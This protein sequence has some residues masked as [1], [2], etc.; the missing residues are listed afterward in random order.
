MTKRA[1][2]V[3]HAI[4]VVGFIAL[5][6]GEVASAQAAPLSID[7]ALA[8][9]SFQPYAPIPV[10]PDGRW[11]AYTLKY[12]DRATDEPGG[13][14]TRTGISSVA[15]GTRVRIT[16]VATGRT[17]PVGPDSATSWGPSWSPDG[18]YLAY[19][20][21]TDGIS[22]LWVRETATGRTRR[23]SNA[24]V[25]AHQ[26]IQYPRWTPDSRR[27]VMPILPYGS[28]RPEA[29]IDS[30]TT[31]AAR[32]RTDSATVRVL[33]ADPAM[34]YGGQAKGARDTDPHDALR[35]DLGLVDVVSGAV[36]TLAT[37]YWPLEYS[38][39]AD[40]RYVTFSSEKP[41]VFRTRWMVPYDLM[42][43][44]IRDGV[45]GPSRRIAKDVAITN[46]SRGVFWSPRGQ[47]LAFSATDSTG[48]EQYFAADSS[49]WAPRLVA[50]SQAT[51]LAADSIAA[52][53]SFWSRSWSRSFWWD[54]TGRAIHIVGAHAVATVSMPDGRVRSV[55]R[56]PVDYEP[57]AVVETIRR[58]AAWTSGGRELT[59][60]FRN[61]VTK[62]MGFGRI[63]LATGAWRVLREED[64]Y[65]GNRRHVPLD[66]TS[67][68]SVVYRGEDAAHPTDVW[69]ASPDLSM[70]HRLTRVA[71]EMERV[72]LG[73]TR[74]IDFTTASGAKRRATLLLP[75][76]Y[77]PG[78]RYPLV[79]YPYP[80]D[81]RSNDVN[82]FGVTGTGVENMQLLAT[83]GFAVLAPDVAPFDMSDEMRELAA[84]ILPGVDRVIELGIA[85]STRLGIMGHSWG[86]Y[87]VLA[88]I[89]QTP[90]FG[91]AVMRG[92][93][94]DQTAMTGTLQTSGYAYGTMLQQ[95]M[96]GG[97]LW[98]RKDVFIRNSPIYQLDR[99]RTPLLII[100]GEAETTVPIFLADQVFAG[101][102]RL[103][104]EVEFARYAHENHGESVWSAAN[105][106][107]FLTR[108]T[109]WFT[110]HLMPERVGDAMKRE[111]Q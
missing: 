109:G 24:I 8:Q 83:R 50:T 29:Q 23:V 16:E 46:Y 43:V 65:L 111:R 90:R 13:W 35:A 60:A 72:P 20:S 15:V 88:L 54:E 84:M 44:S 74:L 100:H 12:P 14:F 11:V 71:P 57:L 92:G 5:A 26:A 66:V 79:V 108:M 78:T 32:R 96:F 95:L 22:R 2:V 31:R 30:T 68:G 62:R 3:M 48:T 40:G 104:R 56:V 106:R 64:R 38:I 93:L 77:Q 89:A 59:V 25:R 61:Q 110:S 82:V 19:Y 10:S 69:I 73:S 47:M 9:P 58:E 63:D 37:G 55:A 27:V 105:Q 34:P 91:A 49:D 107:D 103:G 18:H 33:R 86:G 28:T 81:D 6:G 51:I 101:L 98:E 102:Q 39:S 67:D 36:Q 75:P 42:L 52:S 45:P 1:L 53:A 76:G 7:A 41:A 4:A 85:D 97:T 80:N 87:T 99:V 17:L 94:G 21:N 70:T